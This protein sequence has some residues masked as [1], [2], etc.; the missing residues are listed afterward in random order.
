M[1]KSNVYRLIDFEA[2]LATPTKGYEGDWP[3]YIGKIS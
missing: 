3:P 2:N 1:K